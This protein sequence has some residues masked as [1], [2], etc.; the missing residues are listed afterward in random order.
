MAWVF[1]YQKTPESEWHFAES[2]HREK[3]LEQD[4]AFTTILDLNRIVDDDIT[5]AELD[6]ISYQGPLYFDFDSEDIDYVLKPFKSFLTKLESMGVNLNQCK[7]YA[8]GG[9]GFHVL[10][11]MELFVEKPTGRGF[12]FLPQIYKEMA[13][14]MAVDTLDLRVYSARKGRMFRTENVQRTNGK[15]KVRITTHEAKTMTAEL[16]DEL[17]SAKR[18]IN[19]EPQQAEF[20][21]TLSALFA[22]SG[23]KVRNKISSRKSKKDDKL[24][25]QFNN[26]FPPTFE[27]IAK[28]ENIAKGVGF[29]RIATQL[30]ITA[31]TL[32][33]SE[34]ELLK[35]CEGLIQN[36][37]SD[38][39]RY[40]TPAKR[41]KELSR[42]FY[43]M[44]DNPCYDFSAGGL[45][46]LL[47]D[48]GKAQDLQLQPELPDGAEMDESD[49]ELEFDDDIVKGIRLNRTGIFQR[50]YDKDS[51][52][53]RVRRLSELGLDGITQVCFLEGFEVKGFEFDTYINGHYKGRRAV[54]INNFNTVTGLQ[55]ALGSRDAAAIQVNE[56]QA[57]GMLD[58]FRKKAE[59]EKRVVIALP[60]EGVDVIQIPSSSPDRRFQDV[61]LYVSRGPEGV[62]PLR[63]DYKFKL[64][65]LRSLDG[66]F[67]VDLLDAPPLENTTR[68]QT[69]FHEF[70]KLYPTHIMAR[71]LGYYLACH[72]SQII[73]HRF[74]K[75]P[76]L[77]IYGTAG[78]GKTAIG[79][80]MANL[81]TYKQKVPVFSAGATTGFALRAFLESS[82][83]IPVMFDEYKVSELGTRRVAEFNQVMRNNYTGNS[84]S[85]GFVQR[86]V[87]QS[88]VIISRQAS[89]APLVFL[90]EQ[91]EEQTAILDRSITVNMNTRME[92]RG[93]PADRERKERY[94]QVKQDI[95]DMGYLGSWGLMCVHALVSMDTQEFVKTVNNFIRDLDLNLTRAGSDRPVFNNAVI[96][97]GLEFGKK[98]LA[99]V[100]GTEFDATMEKFQS[101]ILGNIDYSMPTNK[102]ENTKVL[103][104]P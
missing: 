77:Q 89:T 58:I 66:E 8:T 31:V 4:P 38:G 70:F 75:F 59:I 98:I 13:W 34:T 69:F 3:V 7:L 65:G 61:V 99:E 29:Q 100:F 95:E 83:S 91:L 51:E 72:L 40:N 86:D 27:S 21:L 44:L 49:E 96:L 104:H 76:M 16:Y 84:S 64:E 63:D 94:H 50:Y 85:Q 81:H 46:S 42:M 60:R 90:G 10:I 52:E 14:D 11:P 57:R 54:S 32:G 88:Q 62:I 28:G 92:S 25:A 36:H 80:L 93:T 56:A 23:D 9:R 19:E 43:Y 47:E 103:V 97:T 41:S 67:K 73:R 39:R 30:A 55:Q 74:G 45:I 18:F 17:T 12:K 101:E 24:V 20:N 102:S 87:G 35:A 79:Q 6:E 22:K 48:K 71:V 82:A 78:A 2:K 1:Y 5:G 68:S 37:E 33:K 15:Y 26:Q 53:W